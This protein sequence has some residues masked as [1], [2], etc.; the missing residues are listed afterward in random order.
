MELRNLNFIKTRNLNFICEETEAQRG[1]VTRQGHTF[2]KCGPGTDS[3]SDPESADFL[4][5]V[6]LTPRASKERVP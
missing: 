2:S 6:H 4:E 1:K 3:Q 5:E